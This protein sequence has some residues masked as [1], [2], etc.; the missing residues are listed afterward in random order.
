MVET[1]DNAGA[2]AQPPDDPIAHDDDGEASEDN[3]ANLI[4]NGTLPA[5]TGS[6][7]RILHEISLA[8]QRQ[9]AEDLY[10]LLTNV[11]VSNLELNGD[12]IPRVAL[13][14]VPKSSAVRVV[15]SIGLGSHGI[16]QRAPW[17]ESIY[18]SLGME[19]RNWAPLR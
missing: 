4:Y 5:P 7:P 8:D 12:N 17:Q 14:N 2:D 19:V 1:G 15:Y 10:S 9:Q 18:V 13:V 16:G 11:N 6:I 3:H